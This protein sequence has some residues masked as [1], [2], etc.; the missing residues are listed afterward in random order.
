MKAMLSAKLGKY[1]DAIQAYDKGIELSPQFTDIYY[2]KGVALNDQKR[3]DDA[4]GAFNKVNE[5]NPKDGVVAY[6]QIGRTLSTAGR[7][8]EAIQA[9]NK[10]IQAFNTYGEWWPGHIHN[11]QRT[12][13]NSQSGIPAPCARFPLRRG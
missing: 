4:I 5:V 3:Y 10:S 13:R 8:D 6:Y 1:T 11:P 7:Y 9:Y 12:I 2:H